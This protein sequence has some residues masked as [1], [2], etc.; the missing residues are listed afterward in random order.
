MNGVI[1]IAFFVC[2]ARR[3]LAHARGRV[4]SFPLS[5]DRAMTQS[6]RSSSRSPA[7]RARRT[8]CGCSSRWSPPGAPCGSIV[9]TH[10]FRLLHTEIGHRR[11]RRAARSTSAREG[12]DDARDRVRRHRSRCA[13]RRRVRARTRGMVICPVLDGHDLRPSP[14]GRRARWWSAPPTW[15]SRSGAADCSCR[16]RRRCSAIHLENMLRRDAGRRRRDAGGAGLLSPPAAHRRPGGLRRRARPRPPRRAEHALVGAGAANRTRSTPDDGRFAD[17]Q[18]PARCTPAGHRPHLRHAR[19]WCA[20]TCTARWRASTSSCT[21]VTSCGDEVLD[22]ARAHRTGRR[23]LRQLRRVRSTP[24]SSG[25]LSV[26]VAR[27]AHPREPRPRAGCPRP[28]IACWP[29][30]TPT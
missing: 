6:R 17:A 21:R 12:W 1:S 24:D 8:R 9:S 7:R 26:T 16:A 27:R 2:R 23:R 20:P 19:A 14:R 25:R 15:R 5:A 11:R 13:R 3:A 28:S 29:P 4:T 18:A 22:G 30:T 10:G